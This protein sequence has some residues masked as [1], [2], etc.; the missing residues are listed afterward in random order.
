MLTLFLP[1]LFLITHSEGSRIVDTNRSFHLEQ[2]D[3]LTSLEP[4]RS[5]TAS[6]RAM[7]SDCLVSRDNCGVIGVGQALGWAGDGAYNSIEG[8]M[9]FVDVAS[10]DAVYQ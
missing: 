6:S 4:A 9:F 3:T 7:F 8:T 1:I 10:V 5:R 2:Y